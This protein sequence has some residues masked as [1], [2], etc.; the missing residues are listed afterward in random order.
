MGHTQ[1]HNVILFSAFDRTSHHH[2]DCVHSFLPF[3]LWFCFT[4][5]KRHSLFMIVYALLMLGQQNN[6]Y[7]YYY[8]YYHLYL[9][10]RYENKEN[11]KFALQIHLRVWVPGFAASFLDRFHFS[12]VGFIDTFLSLYNKVHPFVFVHNLR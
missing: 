2:F 11:P 1:K 4:N 7:Y 6:E 5:F 10:V 12:F 3:Q 8:Y 9:A